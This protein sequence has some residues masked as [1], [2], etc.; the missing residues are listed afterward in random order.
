MQRVLTTFPRS[1]FGWAL[2]MLFYKK[3]LFFWYQNYF[4]TNFFRVQPFNSQT[5]V[6]CVL[7]G[8]KSLLLQFFFFKKVTVQGLITSITG[9]PIHWT[10]LLDWTTGLKIYPQNLVSCTVTTTKS[11]CWSSAK[12]CPSLGH[13]DIYLVQCNLSIVARTSALISGMH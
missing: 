10:G 3:F 13:Q 8:E 6:E 5:I 1:S 4:Y 7:Q 2:D 9:V 11:Y 12:Q